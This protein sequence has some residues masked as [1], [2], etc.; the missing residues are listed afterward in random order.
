VLLPALARVRPTVMVTVPL[1]MEKI[2]R[3]RVLPE[4]QRYARYGWPPL[5]RLLN[6]VAGLKLR[7]LFGGCLRFFGIGGAGI[8]MAEAAVAGLLES[9]R[10]DVNERLAA[11]SRV[12]RVQLQREPFEKTPT[13]KIKR[14]VYPLRSS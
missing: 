8:A 9:L 6:L 14:H 4:L 5:R 10:Q 12:Q 1:V 11:F 7:R 3:G 2:V 13:P